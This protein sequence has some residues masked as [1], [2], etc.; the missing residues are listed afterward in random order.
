MTALVL[1]W[2]KCGSLIHRPGAALKLRGQDT[3]GKTDNV[4]RSLC[5]FGISDSRCLTVSM[6]TALVGVC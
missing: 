5:I 2:H 1:N 4:H 6:V 3:Y